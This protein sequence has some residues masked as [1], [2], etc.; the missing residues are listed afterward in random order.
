M[1]KSMSLVLRAAQGSDF[2]CLLLLTKTIVEEFG[3][4]RLIQ[5][6]SDLS[7]AEFA[8]AFRT[9]PAWSAVVQVGEQIAGYVLICPKAE[10]PLKG[11][12]SKL[13]VR[14]EFRR[15][16]LDYLLINAGIAAAQ[17]LGFSSLYIDTARE[18]GVESL[19]KR[20]GAKEVDDSRHDIATSLAMELVIPEHLVFM[21]KPP[22]TSHRAPH[23]VNLGCG[24]EPEKVKLQS[25]KNAARAL[26]ESPD[27]LATI[28]R[29]KRAKCWFYWKFAEAWVR[30]ETLPSFGDD[31]I[32]AAMFLFNEEPRNGQ[33]FAETRANAFREV[34]AMRFGPILDDSTPT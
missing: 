20:F 12:L 34:L 11:E 21:R 18:F 16:G 26:L 25:L 22:G 23:N 13:Y 24:W 17:D 14:P 4:T 29:A 31:C 30:C 28:R 19:Y 15:Q 5:H 10:D 3:I 8:E 32:S 1:N 2:P 27:D 6:Y 9:K 33:R 7:I